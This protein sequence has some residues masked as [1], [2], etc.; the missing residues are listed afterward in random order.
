MFDIE[1]LMKEIAK[2]SRKIKTDE[3]PAVTL[4]QKQAAIAMAALEKTLL[5]LL[6][7]GMPHKVIFM[8]LFYFWLTLEAPMRGVSEA[9]LERHAIFPDA[10]SA[11]I[12]KT[13][14]ENSLNQ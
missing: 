10:V 2:I 12:L 6:E 4:H 13:A 9:H 11:I 3:L 8:S 1:L 14:V 5:S 7:A